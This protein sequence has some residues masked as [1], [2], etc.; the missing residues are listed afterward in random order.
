MVKD[1]TYDTKKSKA[2]KPLIKKHS[3]DFNG[4][5][6][7]KECIRLIGVANNSYYKY[8]RELKQD[9]I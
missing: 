7:D 1:T 3:R 2:V 8:K 6:I 5:L 4:M 9:A